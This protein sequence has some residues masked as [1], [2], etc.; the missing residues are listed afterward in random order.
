MTDEK[1]AIELL[2]LQRF[3]RNR[4]TPRDPEFL[5]AFGW[6]TEGVVDLRSRLETKMTAVVSD[7]RRKE[8]HQNQPDSRTCNKRSK[9]LRGIIRA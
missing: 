7:L 8:M 1:L 9:T 6:E 5:L 2:T 4:S 3:W